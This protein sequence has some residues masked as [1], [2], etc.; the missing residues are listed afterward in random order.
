MV[1]LIVEKD[2]FQSIHEIFHQEGGPVFIAGPCA[3]ESKDQ[4]TQVA[5]YLGELGVRGLRGGAYKPRSSPYSFQGLGQ[6]GL[7]HLEEAGCASGL[8]TVSEIVDGRYLDQVAKH[9]DVLQVGA[10]NMSNFELLKLV[11]QTHKRVDLFNQV[12]L[13][14][15]NIRTGVSASVK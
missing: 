6:K 15:H 10:R 14:D 3:V 13:K 2:S 7:Q 8:V 9:V 11:G 12:W 4:M 1:P 5:Q